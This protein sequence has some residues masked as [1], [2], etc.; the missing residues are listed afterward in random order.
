M[1]NNQY[2]LLLKKIFVIISFLPFLWGEVGYAQAQKD[3]TVA[4]AAST[5]SVPETQPES[6][7]EGTQPE[8]SA[9]KTKQ[10]QISGRMLS[11]EVIA[12]VYKTL[13][14]NNPKKNKNWIGIWQGTQVNYNIPPL[15]KTMMGGETEDGD[16]AF[17]SL[18]LSRKDYILGYG[19]GEI[20]TTIAATLSFSAEGLPEGKPFS[21]SV[22]ALDFGSNYVVVQFK[23]PLGN[24]PNAN[25]NWIGLWE[26]KT[27]FYEGL[28]LYKKVPVKSNVNE[29][30][31][32]I[33]DILLK[34]NTFYTVV[35][36]TGAGNNDIAAAY[37]FKTE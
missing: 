18:K 3:D 9:G 11:G 25:N 21:T 20:L 14:G 10:L 37:I 1:K 4:E 32:S 24:I 30:F 29:G 12:L 13:A 35:Y 27:F 28:N 34:R 16:Q 7:A 15:F 22:K 31:A 19:T 6:P 23:T 36:S 5:Q 2:F 26:G 33:N 17:D 8:V